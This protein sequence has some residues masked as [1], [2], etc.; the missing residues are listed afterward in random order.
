MRLLICGSRDW[1]D[2][3]PIVRLLDGYYSEYA[4]ADGL[5]VIEGCARGAD[6]VAHNWAEVALRYSA[7]PIVIEHL[8]FPAEWDRYGKRAGR[9]RNRLMMSEGKPDE[10]FAF[11]SGFDWSLSAGGTEDMVG[12]ARAAGVPA[13][14]IGR[15]S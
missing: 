14:V 3:G 1:D 8:C 10:V 15:A 13:Y 2:P 7:D 11:K 12:V 6:K 4:G 9:V 5:T